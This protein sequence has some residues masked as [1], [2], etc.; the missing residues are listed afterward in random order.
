MCG[1]IPRQKKKK[2]KEPQRDALCVM[3]PVPREGTPFKGLMLERTSF[4]K[5]DD[6]EEFRPS[7]A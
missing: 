7:Y 2:K 3:P 1:K 6:S 4:H 5:K